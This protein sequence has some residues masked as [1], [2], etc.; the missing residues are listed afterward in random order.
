MYFRIIMTV[1]LVLSTSCEY[2]S[3]STKNKRIQDK[4]VLNENVSEDKKVEEKGSYG[5][6]YGELLKKIQTNDSKSLLVV[7]GIVDVKLFGETSLDPKFYTSKEYLGYLN[8]YVKLFTIFKSSIDNL[9]TN[10][11]EF[12]SE[13]NISLKRFENRFVNPCVSHD[14]CE[15]IKRSLSKEGYTA[16]IIE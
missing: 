14:R 15:L 8:L 7:L 6:E 16:S 3:V 12:N 10:K 13:F 1:V 5:K 4:L 9:Q 2:G 11:G